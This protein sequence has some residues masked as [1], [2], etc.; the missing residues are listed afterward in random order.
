MGRERFKKAGKGERKLIIWHGSWGVGDRRL[1]RLVGFSA[2]S[3]VPS[4]VLINVKYQQG[5][6]SSIY[7]EGEVT[8]GTQGVR[9][10]G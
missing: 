6:D 3:V 7:P 8:W 4:H 5:M 2:Q 10:R 1:K 9:K